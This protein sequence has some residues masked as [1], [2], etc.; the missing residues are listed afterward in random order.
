[1]HKILILILLLV[2]ALL[3]GCGRW[4][5]ERYDAEVTERID[6]SLP[7]G[8]TREQFLATFPDAVLIDEQASGARYLVHKEQTCFWCYS[9]AGFQRSTDVFA[10]VVIFDG[11]TL[12]AV[13]PAREA[14]P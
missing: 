7:Q 11:D 6:V 1:V 12:S 14:S 13:E 3:V 4:H 5:V 10:R 8:M 2:P 9:G